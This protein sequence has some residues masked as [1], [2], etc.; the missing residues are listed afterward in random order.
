MNPSSQSISPKLSLLRR[1]LNFVLIGDGCWEWTGSRSEKGYGRMWFVG[2]EE[3]HQ[4]SFELFRG[5]RPPH[6]MVMHRCNN[7]GCVRPSH[8]QLGTNQ[9]NIQAAYRDGLCSESRKS[10]RGERHFN[11]KL[12]EKDVLAIRSAPCHNTGKQKHPVTIKSLAKQFGVTTHTIA[13]V[14]GK[15]LWRW[16]P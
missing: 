2:C 16:L 14:R 3:A 1:F 13:A 12:T 8:L 11:S 9:E 7:K 10:M 5:K 6:L 4:V 15:R